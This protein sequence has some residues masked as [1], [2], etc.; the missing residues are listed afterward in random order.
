MSEFEPN[1]SGGSGKSSINLRL[2][3]LDMSKVNFPKKRVGSGL[4]RSQVRI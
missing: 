1:A 2:N 4:G 3:E